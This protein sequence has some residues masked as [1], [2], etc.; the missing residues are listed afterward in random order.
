MSTISTTRATER[1]SRRLQNAGLVSGERLRS[2][3]R[4]YRLA[5]RAL[6][7]DAYLSWRRMGDRA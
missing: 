5:G 1:I 7:A 6:E 2:Q 3:P 4:L